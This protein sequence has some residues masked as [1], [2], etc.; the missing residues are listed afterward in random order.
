[1][2]FK[3]E[4]IR[5]AK[6]LSRRELAEKSGVAE[7]NIQRLETFSN[8]PRT[9]QLLTLERLAKALGCKVRDFFPK[10]KYI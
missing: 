5:K 8:D 7:Q 2:D 4:E 1:M 9:A 6:G 3:L 10:E